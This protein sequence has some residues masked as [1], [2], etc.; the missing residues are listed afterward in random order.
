MNKIQTILNKIYGH[1]SYNLSR[2]CNLEKVLVILENF[3]RF[4]LKFETILNNLLKF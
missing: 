4:S 3:E 2:F 1:F